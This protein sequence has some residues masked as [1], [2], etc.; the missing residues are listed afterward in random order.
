MRHGQGGVEGW[1]V[2]LAEAGWVPDV[3]LRAGIRSLIRRRRDELR[4]ADDAPFLE[5]MRGSPLALHTDAANSQHYEVPPAF[6]EQVLGPRLKYSCGLFPSPD[7]SLE[8]AEERMLELTCERAGIRDGMSILDL[9]CGWGS[10]SHWIA[11]RYPACRVLAVSNSGPQREFIVRRL[12]E[13]GLGG[14]EV[15]TADVSDFDPGRRFDRVISVEMFEHVRNWERLLHRVATWLAPDGRAFL[16]VF[17]HARRTYPFE[18]RARDDWMGRHFFTGG[19]MPSE[20][21][22][23]RLEIPLEVEQ[24]WRVDG[25]HYQRT[26]DAWLRNLDA[27]AAALRS[28]LV[29]TYGPGRADTWLRRWRI[30]FMA[31]SELFGFEDRA[32]WGVVHTRLAPLPRSGA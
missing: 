11:E 24:R 14:V 1:P 20:D 21:L 31:V 5:E 12:D 9:G 4:G 17:C 6:F 23:S 26:S 15:V 18:T 29:Q 7:T 13:R 8:R 27:R 10:L 30:F 19:L 22:L 3:A 28:T 32:E 25:R 16:H 2:R